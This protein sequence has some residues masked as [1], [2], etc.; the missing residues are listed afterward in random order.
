MLPPFPRA[1]AT[2]KSEL[3]INSTK[4]ATFH[5]H[6]M[7]TGGEASS[8]VPLALGAG[9]APG[10]AATLAAKESQCWSVAA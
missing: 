2:G 7:E 3:S 4:L 9:S 8:A 10:L 1:L 5:S 6:C